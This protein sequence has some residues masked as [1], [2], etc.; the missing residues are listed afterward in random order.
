MLSN[1][2]IGDRVRSCLTGWGTVKLIENNDCY[3]VIIN[4]DNGTKRSFSKDGKYR[5]LDE[6]P[7]IVEVQ[8]KKWKPEGGNYFIDG[9]GII[10]HCKTFGGEHIQH[11]NEGR[12]YPTRELAEKAY[13]TIRRFQRLV[14]YVLEHAPD[15][16][17]CWNNENQMKAYLYYNHILGKWDYSHHGT[18]EVIAVVMPT[19]VARKLCEKLNS[20]EVKL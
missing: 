1:V 18:E 17:P 13:Q 9:Q 2:K 15:W 14:A 8:K 12:A 4:F 6:K 5:F 10:W 20:G 19:N 16:E 7:E 11:T 3:S